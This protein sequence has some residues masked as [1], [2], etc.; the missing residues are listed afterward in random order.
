M[1]GFVTPGV[2]RQEVLPT[3]P[4]ELRT[5]VPAFLGYASG[6]AAVN[7]PVALASSA[8][9]IARFGGPM[10][11]SY[12]ANAVGGFFS[13]GGTLCYAVRL[14]DLTAPEIALQIGLDS[15][16]SLDTIDLIA[17]PDIMRYRQPGNLKPDPGQVT[18]MQSALIAHCQLMGDRFAILDSLPGGGVVAQR[19]GIRSPNAALYYPWI[20]TSAGL[21]PPCG[22][23]AGVYARADSQTGVHKAPA[24][25]ALE[26]VVDVEIPVS[27][28]DQGALNP[29]GINC[30]RAFP[31]RGILV[32]GARTLSSDPA[33][34]YVSTRRIFLTAARWISRNLAGFIYEPNNEA[35]W[36]L[37]T[38]ELNSYFLRLYES[39]ALAGATPQSSFYVKCDAENNPPATRDLGML[40][41]EIGL[42]PGVPSEFVVV[43]IVQTASGATIATQA[44]S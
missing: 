29:L 38:R 43:R 32:W 44:S 34:I 24:N 37:V 19:A 39:G 18:I 28:A 23:V 11:G 14:D 35:L 4:A 9:F 22:H 30:I 25:A 15:I 33:W 3:P 17:A 13:N 36:A 40:V 5:G 16:S 6:M 12:L 8:D 20:R 21:M 41:T 7:T 1:T 26:D 10:A 2:Y 27:G 31:G 42:A